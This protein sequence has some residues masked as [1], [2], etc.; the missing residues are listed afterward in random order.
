MAKIIIKYENEME[1]IKIIEALSKGIKL[2]AIG[3]PHKSGKYYRVY[4]DIL[5]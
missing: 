5:E 2:G 4:I 1:K 3:K